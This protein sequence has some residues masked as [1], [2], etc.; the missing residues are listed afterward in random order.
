MAD[1]FRIG[2]IGRALS[3]GFGLFAERKYKEEQDRIDRAWQMQLQNIA[4]ARADAR[5]EQD[6]QR[7]LAISTRDNALAD[8]RAEA[9]RQARAEEKRLDREARAGEFDRLEDRRTQERH[10]DMV[11]ARREALAETLDRIEERY[12]KQR[13]N[14]MI[15][16]NPEKM[17]EIEL[18]Y[19][20]ERDQAIGSF[21]QSMMLRA[22]E[23]P[24]MEAYMQ[25]RGNTRDEVAAMMEGLGASYEGANTIADRFMKWSKDPGAVD[26]GAGGAPWQPSGNIMTPDGGD[27]YVRPGTSAPRMD[28]SPLTPMPEPP[29]QQPGAMSRG[30][31]RLFEQSGF[32]QGISRRMEDVPLY[33]YRRHGSQQ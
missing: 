16:M 12:Q 14:P 8:Q 9:D 32:A 29:A 28:P 24:E 7:R 21:G 6:F 23:Y 15:S 22:Q 33:D 31:S 25:F 1:K 11:M 17:A 18:A 30:A 19:R 26:A 20:N 13:E 5:D 4:N 3:S 10:D 27:T 2:Q